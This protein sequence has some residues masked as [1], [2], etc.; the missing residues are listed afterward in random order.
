M[1]YQKRR[2][3][4]PGPEADLNRGKRR[5]TLRPYGDCKL[6]FMDTFRPVESHRPDDTLPTGLVM[7][8]KAFSTSPIQLFL[9]ACLAGQKL[10][11]DLPEHARCVIHW[12][13]IFSSVALLKLN[14]LEHL[15]CLRIQGC[16]D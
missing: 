14:E 1:R 16:K 12:P 11:D 5:I 13:V 9:A 8:G 6:K 15:E 7:L 2:I 10:R 3:K 4:N